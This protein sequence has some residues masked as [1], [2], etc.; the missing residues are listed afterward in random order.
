[1]LD[2]DTHADIISTHILMGVAHDDQ[3]D[4]LSLEQA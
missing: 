3:L 2:L 1:M 4:D